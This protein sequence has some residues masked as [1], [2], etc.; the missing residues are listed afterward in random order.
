MAD[1]SNAAV[2]GALVVEPETITVEV[3]ETKS[4]AYDIAWS[5]RAEEA[6]SIV[7]GL[8]AEQITD[9]SALYLVSLP[10]LTRHWQAL[11]TSGRVGSISRTGTDSE[12]G[13]ESRTRRGAGGR[14]V[15]PTYSFSA[16]DMFGDPINRTRLLNGKRR[17]ERDLDVALWKLFEEIESL[18]PNVMLSLDGFMPVGD[19]QYANLAS[20]CDFMI[21]DKEPPS[22]EA[23]EFAELYE[24]LVNEGWTRHTYK[25]QKQISDA[26]ITDSFDA[27]AFGYGMMI[28]FPADPDWTLLAA[29]EV[30]DFDQ[31]AQM[32]WTEDGLVGTGS[33]DKLVSADPDVNTSG[34]TFTNGGNGGESESTDT[35]S[36]FVAGTDSTIDTTGG[37][38]DT[39]GAQEQTENTDPNHGDTTTSGG[40]QTTQP[41]QEVRLVYPD[42]SSV[43]MPV[44]ASNGEASVAGANTKVIARWG[45]VPF[46]VFSSD[47][48]LVSVFAFHRNG[49]EKVEFYVDGRLAATQ[50]EGVGGEFI[51]RLDIATFPDGAHTLEAVV[52]PMHGKTRTLSGQYD[53]SKSYGGTEWTG[54][55]TLEFF[56][57]AYGSVEVEV[58]ELPAG[59]H[60]WGGPDSLIYNGIQ[61]HKDRWYI[62][63]PAPGVT[64]DQVVINAGLTSY[65]SGVWYREFEKIKLENL[66]I[67]GHGGMLSYFADQHDMLWFDNVVIEGPGMLDPSGAEAAAK[68]QWWTGCDISNSRGGMVRQFVRDC[69]ISNIGEDVIREGNLV[70]NVTIDTVDATGTAWHSGVIANPIAHDNRIYSNVSMLNLG[71]S[72]AWAFRNG[73]S[74]HWEHKDVAI[75]N[76]KAEQNDPNAIAFYCGG[77]VENILIRDSYFNGHV[78]WRDDTSTNPD[79]LFKPNAS[80]AVYI[81]HASRLDGSYLYIPEVHGVERID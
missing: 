6:R 79:W 75:V 73:T 19:G 1:V 35:D 20:V 11:A 57:N 4:L 38:E 72:R 2:R 54:E 3:P 29:M 32:A 30:P 27:E 77:T 48:D 22:A 28:V 65:P 62:F 70:V 5:T 63:R 17:Y 58:V 24:R 21:Q 39:D 61:N 45:T 25:I 52:Y 76:C 12:D 74:N 44:V 55:Y 23:T 53:I 15:T 37:E 69:T 42:A 9:P 14:D 81:T 67:R 31:L 41:P 16:T 26:M 33:D 43:M 18:R 59:N 47:D 8:I 68:H 71:A 13:R 36:D 46:Q 80:D 40:E 60:T 51:A 34:S 66:T 10:Q 78:L 50:T 49:V 7:A 56:T 64:R